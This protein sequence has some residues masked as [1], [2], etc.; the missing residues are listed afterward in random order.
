M[1]E[2]S[3]GEPASIVCVAGKCNPKARCTYF[4]SDLLLPLG[5]MPLNA[6][7]DDGSLKS[8]AKP[9]T[10]QRTTTI[11][12]ESQASMDEKMKST[13]PL[14]E[15]LLASFGCLVLAVLLSACGGGGGGAADAGHGSASD[16][17]P[18]A[19]QAVIYYKKVGR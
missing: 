1:A 7:E 11:L 15:S 4:P 5:R 8:I 6:F 18:S 2:P 13:L 19:N 9:E 16:F 10:I 17:E 3:E 12:V 14:S